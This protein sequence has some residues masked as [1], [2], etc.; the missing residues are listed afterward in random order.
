MTR[1]VVVT[2]GSRGI[3]LAIAENFAADHNV[4]IVWNSTPPADLPNSVYALQSDLTSP[5]SCQECIEK[6]IKKFGQLD[7]I[8]NNAGFSQI[9]PVEEFDASACRA[10]LDVNL[11]V[12][13][14][15]L[16]AAMPHLRSGA[17]IV[18]ISSINAV[19][20]PKS[21]A[22]FGAS[23]AALNL[24]TRAMAKELGS[25]GIRVN[26][27]SPGAVNVPDKPR[28]TELIDLFVKDTALGRIAEPEDIARVVRFISS[29]DAGFITG[30]VVT[31]SGGYRL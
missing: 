19:L 6:V 17:S 21:A 11:L 29:E 8:V 2:G 15:L 18:N 3:G 9:T 27:V 7:V 14:D 16:S 31:V 1:T 24:W 10:I 23:K 12:P 28:P 5:G 13:N 22:I 4:A 25:H 26:A 30:E 20:P